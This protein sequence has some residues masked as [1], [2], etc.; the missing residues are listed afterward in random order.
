M[1]LGGVAVGLA[2]AL[3][4]LYWLGHTFNDAMVDISLTVTS[5]Y[6]TFFV[7][8]EVCEASGVL[9]VVTLGAYL[10]AV[11]KPFFQVRKEI[12][13]TLHHFWEMASY[14]ANTIIFILA[15][16]IIGRMFVE[17]SDNFT[18][19]DA[20]WLL[21]FYVWMNVARG[22]MILML[23]PL[24]RRIGYGLDWQNAAVMSW[25]GLRGAVGLALALVVSLE[26]QFPEKDRARVMFLTGGVVILTLVVNGTTTA[27]L[28]NYLNLNPGSANKERALANM[29][30]ELQEMCMKGY[31]D[32]FFDETLGGAS[33]DTV[34]EYVSTLD[35]MPTVSV[36]EVVQSAPRQKLRRVSTVSWLF[37]NENI[38]NAPSSGE[39]PPPPL[40]S[41]EERIADVRSRFLQVRMR[42]RVRVGVRVRVRRIRVRR[43][44]AKV[45]VRVR[46]RV[47]PYLSFS[48]EGADGETRVLH[49]AGVRQPGDEHVAHAAGVRGQRAGSHARAAA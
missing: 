25:G 22:L 42:V 4:T 11:G 27:S 30:H 19:V 43:V 41:D 49:P 26:K 37:G 35:K 23:Y 28:L 32:N 18:A 5:C 7:A 20:G 44:R 8:E 38:M 47:S 48:C 10:G 45:R 31:L 6:L 1:P 14:V 46:V 3:G 16:V 34:Q 33:F 2:A 12:E 13:E 9:A 40:A 24:L 39:V 17:T 21:L 15:G 36:G 29:R